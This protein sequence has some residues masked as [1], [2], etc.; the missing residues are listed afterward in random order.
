MVKRKLVFAI[1]FTLTVLMG[2]FNSIFYDSVIT[3]LK[4]TPISWLQG[5]SDRNLRRDDFTDCSFIFFYTLC[6]IAIPQNDQKALGFAPSSAVSKAGGMFLQF[7]QPS[8]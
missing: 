5:L 2:I 4:F 1:G 7:F 8:K 3:N 6:I